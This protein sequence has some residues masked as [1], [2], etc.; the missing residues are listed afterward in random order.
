MYSHFGKVEFSLNVKQ[1]VSLA[2]ADGL[3][4]SLPDRAVVEVIPGLAVSGE[5]GVVPAAGAGSVV[6]DHSGQVVQ[7]A[8]RVG[9]PG[10]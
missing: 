9:V 6:D 2:G 5:G 10:P 1:D 8:P 3:V 7:A 4:V